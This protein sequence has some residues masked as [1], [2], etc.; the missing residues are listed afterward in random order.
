MAVKYKQKCMLCR[1]NYVVTNWK[2]RFPKCYECQ[3]KEL[4]GEID[5]PKMKKFF[6]I[7]EELYK[8]NAFLRSIKVNYLTYGNLSEKQIEAFKKV[9]KDLT[10]PSD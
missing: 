10:D 4:N 3:R 9:V 6:D 1:K 5:D 7:P 8:Q 2:E